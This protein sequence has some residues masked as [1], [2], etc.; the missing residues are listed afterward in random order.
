ERPGGVGSLVRPPAGQHHDDQ[1][2]APSRRRFLSA[3][4]RGEFGLRHSTERRWRGRP[5]G[6]TAG[7]SRLRQRGCR[8]G[9]GLDLGGGLRLLEAHSLESDSTAWDHALG[10][11]RTQADEI[12]SKTY[13]LLGLAIARDGGGPQ[14]PFWECSNAPR[15]CCRYHR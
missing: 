15:S 6:A 1:Q 8:Q 7:A 9:D 2:W 13:A 12:S 10:S 4:R 5:F 14:P 11:A 3:S